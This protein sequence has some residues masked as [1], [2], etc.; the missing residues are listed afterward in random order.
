M[1]QVPFN[2]IGH[3]L[4]SFILRTIK[5]DHNILLNTI[6]EDVAKHMV[7]EAK[8]ASDPISD[9]GNFENSWDLES[10]KQGHDVFNSAPYAANLEYGRLP[11][12]PGPPLEPLLA[13]VQHKGLGDSEEEQH[14]IAFEIQR[15]I[16]EYGTPPH[17][18]L[19]NIVD[20]DIAAWLDQSVQ[21]H[22]A[23]RSRS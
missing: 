23:N 16:H 9:T 7:A 12:R 1:T 20:M 19:G 11:F 5:Q 22:L 17:R 8:Q 21:Q 14:S 6:T 2:Q 13:W 18:I 15:H 10:T 4:E 3:E